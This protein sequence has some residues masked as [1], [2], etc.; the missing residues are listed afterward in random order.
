MQNLIQKSDTRFAQSIFP[1]RCVRAFFVAI[2]LALLMPA[3]AYAA[4][5]FVEGVHFQR[6]P[7]AVDTADAEKVEVVEVFSYACIHCYNFD[8]YVEAWHENQDE[9]VVFYRMPAIFSADWETLAQAFYTAET[10]G[11]SEQVHADLFVG[12]HE[13]QEDLRKPVMLARVFANMAEVSEADFLAAHNSFSVRSRVQQAKAKGRAYQVTGVPTLIV[14]GKYRVD[15][16]M[17]G[18]NAAMLQV[19]DFLVE[20]ERGA[21]AE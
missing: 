20:K 17:A 21:S 6:L 13:R 11:V 4:E 12:I 2:G 1:G 5:K 19:V 7:V 18:G 16:R 3:S 14:N 15:G 9:G 10:L 8:P